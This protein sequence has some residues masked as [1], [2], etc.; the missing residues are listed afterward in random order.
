MFYFTANNILMNVCL[1][2][3][4]AL[5]LVS[6]GHIK[7]ETIQAIEGKNG[8]PKTPVTLNGHSGKES[9]FALAFSD[10]NWGSSTRLLAER[11]KKRTPSQIAAIVEE[12]QKTPLTYTSKRDAGSA[13][14]SSM[15]IDPYADICKSICS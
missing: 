9:H 3:E 1:Q 14:T 7:H 11:V 2:L 5:R 4:R 6:D 10:Q 12:A 8:V 13:A 15:L